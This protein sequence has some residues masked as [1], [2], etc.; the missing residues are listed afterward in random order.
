MDYM[1]NNSH[2]RLTPHTR[3]AAAGFTLLELMV[4]MLL[5]V[6]FLSIALFFISPSLFG[7]P[8]ESTIRDISSTMR[9]ARSLSQ[10]SGSVQTITIDPDAQQYFLKG[11]KKKRI[12]D[13][14]SVS[15]LD[16]LSQEQ[17]NEKYD[18]LFYPFGSTDGTLILLEY[19]NRTVTL[20]LDPVVGSVAVKRE[21]G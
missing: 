7:N 21:S 18:F 12:P 16:P 9:H 2:A 8:L 13:G 5:I 20:A 3:S 1:R 10:I 11:Q 19:K 6:L 14:I 15:V 17:M 4:V